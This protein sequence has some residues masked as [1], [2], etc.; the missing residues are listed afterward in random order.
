MVLFADSHVR[1]S[2]FA[3]AQ[4]SLD[5]AEMLYPYDME[6]VDPTLDYKRGCHVHL[7]NQTSTFAFSKE[8]LHKEARIYL[9][10]NQSS[11]GSQNLWVRQDL[12]ASNKSIGSIR[13]KEVLT[14]GSNGRDMRNQLYI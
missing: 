12:R 2:S 5:F 8:A 1:L 7:M 6:L 9:Y 14:L 13:R 3:Y 11:L 4:I 10:P